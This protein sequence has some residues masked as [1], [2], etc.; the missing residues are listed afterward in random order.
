MRRLVP[1]VVWGLVSLSCTSSSDVGEGTTAAGAARPAR[2]SAPATTATTLPASP[3][4]PR[5][6]LVVSATGDVNLDP[7]YIPALRTRGY[8]HAWSGLQ[9]IFQQDDLSIINLECAVSDLG[10]PEVKEFTFR[11]DP[12]ALPAARAAGVDVANMGNNHSGDF[13]KQALVDSRA[14]LEQAG[15]APVGAGADA[16]T[17]HRPA[18][19]AVDGW[20]VAVVGFGGVVPTPDWLATDRRPG[21]ADGDTIESMVAAVQAADAV[22]D[23]VVVSIHWG[24]ELDT[25]PR[26]EDRARADAL[27]AAGAD[28]IFGHHAHRLQPLEVVQGVPVAWGLGN[29]VWPNHSAAGSRTAVAQVVFAPDGA[30][31]ACLLPAV[32]ESAGH[33]VL[34]AAHDPAAPCPPV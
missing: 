27:I 24:V 15:I 8:E 2:S 21:M 23:I 12:A 7:G 32:I 20:T 9:G 34:Q 25:E 3:A 26:Q 6:Q 14:R 5:G 4:P 29:F 22:A 17:A 19:L 16:A 33:P 28:A 13:G 30:V 1:L 11:C 18:V 31:T 10:V